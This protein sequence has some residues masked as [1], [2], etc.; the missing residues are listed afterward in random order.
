MPFVSP[1]W[2]T[3]SPAFTGGLRAI[4]F[5]GSVDDRRVPAENAENRKDHQDCDKHDGANNEPLMRRNRLHFQHQPFSAVGVS[6]NPGAARAPS[7]IH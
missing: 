1:R 6:S 3:T 7:Q 4:R 5:S 2:M